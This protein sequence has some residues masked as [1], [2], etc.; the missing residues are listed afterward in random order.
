MEEQKIKTDMDVAINFPKL[1][2][3]VYARGSHSKHFADFLI[4]KTSVNGT[5][6]LSIEHLNDNEALKNEECYFDFGTTLGLL[7]SGLFDFVGI[8]I[9]NGKPRF[10][11]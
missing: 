4:R 11:I 8:E 5:K 1:K 9:E 6:T 7:K 3:L 2:H 10:D